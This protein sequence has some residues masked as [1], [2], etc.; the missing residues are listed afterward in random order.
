LKLIKKIH[1]P[2]IVQCYR[3]FETKNQLYI[4]IEYVPGENLLTFLKKLLESNKPFSEN[5]IYKV[6]KQIVSALSYVHD[7][8]LIH[9]NIKLENVIFYKK[10]Q[11]KLIGFDISE[12]SAP[13]NLNHLSDKCSLIY[14]LPEY[15]NGSHSFS[16][17]IWSLGVMLYF[18]LT[19]EFPFQGE[20]SSILSSNILNLP[21]PTINQNYSIE[22]KE[23]I[24][25]MLI[26][27]PN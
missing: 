22:L 23:T 11:I 16:S 26:K 6:F 25:S 4:V 14:K 27:Y 2:N 12:I 5:F 17:D 18:M 10:Y 8:H 9:L 1:H 21:T 19:F 3:Y 13:S 24:Y 7:L 15:I 20:F